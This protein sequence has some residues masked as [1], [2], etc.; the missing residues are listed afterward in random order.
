MTYR[1]A[2]D[3]LAEA[4]QRGMRRAFFV[5]AVLLE[6]EAVRGHLKPLGSVAGRDG[7]IYECGIFSDLGQDWLVVVTETGVGTHPAQSAVTYAHILFNSFE[8]QILVGIG[9]SRKTEAPLGSVVASEY[10]YMPYS[11]KYD[12]KGRSSRPRTFQVDGRLIGIAKKVRRDNTWPSRIRAPNGGTLPPLN[13]YPVNFPPIGLVAPIC[14][15]EAVMADPGSDLEALIA[16]EYGDT[17]VV[18]MEGY[19]AVYAASQERTP[20]IIV[21]GVSDM[22]TPDKLPEKDAVRQPVAACHAAAVRTTTS[23]SAYLRRLA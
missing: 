20:S 14:S 18:E 8:V 19:G 23:V 13:V 16:D 21:R 6:M 1:K 4:E 15:V 7:A 10:V 3:I 5:T 22:T 2:E 12:E 9:G 17:C 11:A